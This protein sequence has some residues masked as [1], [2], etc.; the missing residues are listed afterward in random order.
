M[1]GGLHKGDPLRLGE[2]RMMP[3]QAADPGRPAIVAS[4]ALFGLR[5]DLATSDSWLSS[6]RTRIRAHGTTCRAVTAAVATVLFHPDF[7]RR[8]RNHTESAD[9]SPD[10]GRK[11]LAGLG[12]STLTAGGEFHPALRTSAARAGRPDRNYDQWPG[13]Q[14]GPSCIGKL[15][16]PMT[17]AR[18]SGRRPVRSK[19]LTIEA[20]RNRAGSN[21]IPV[22]SPGQSLA[23]RRSAVDERALCLWMDSGCGC[24]DSANHIT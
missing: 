12:L 6:F 11:A 10:R 7:N 13:R 3:A 2:S 14:Q 15:H 1:P 9:P 18:D 23:A 16:V 5:E 4:G 19:K 22:C 17:A 21:P 8:L 20:G 24:A